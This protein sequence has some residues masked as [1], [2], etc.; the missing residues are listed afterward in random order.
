M[1]FASGRWLIS[2]AEVEYCASVSIYISSSATKYTLF[3]VFIILG[4]L[5]SLTFYDRMSKKK[6]VYRVNICSA[7]MVMKELCYK[8]DQKQE[9]KSLS[10]YRAI[11]CYLHH[12]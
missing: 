11:E 4:I 10:I 2:V 7:I 5:N 8:L 6:N 3:S 1:L 9:N 12:F